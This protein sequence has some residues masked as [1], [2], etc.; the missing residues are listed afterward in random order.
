[1]TT[2]RALRPGDDLA[3]YRVDAC[4]GRGGM[5]EVFRARDERLG[6]DVAIKLL[7]RTAPTT[8]RSATGCCASRASRRASTTPTSCPSTTPARSTDGCTS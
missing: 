1:M 7:A 4:V 2:G 3:G 8:P 5:G 6:R